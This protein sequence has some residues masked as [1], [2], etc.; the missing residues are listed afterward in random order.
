MTRAFRAL[1]LGRL[2]LHIEGP[3]WQWFVAG[4]LASALVYWVVW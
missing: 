1:R 2:V 3:L 4:L